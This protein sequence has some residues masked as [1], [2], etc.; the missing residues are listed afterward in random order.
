MIPRD[1]K[2]TLERLLVSCMTQLNGCREVERTSSI[3]VVTI[4]ELEVEMKYKSEIIFR[5]FHYNNTD[6]RRYSVTLPA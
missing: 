1:L 4:S 6:I 3:A 2:V 5:C